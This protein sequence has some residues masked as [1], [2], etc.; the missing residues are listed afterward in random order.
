MDYILVGVLTAAAAGWII[1]AE[2]N[3]RRNAARQNVNEPAEGAGSKPQRS[4]RE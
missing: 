2:M 3:S 4:F 1:W